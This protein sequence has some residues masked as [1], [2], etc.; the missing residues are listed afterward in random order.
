M[1]GAWRGND[2]CW[3]MAA[4]IARIIAHADGQ[5][6]L[7]KD[8]RTHLVLIDGFIGGEGNGPLDVEP[9]KSGVILFADSPTAADYA[10]ALTMGYCPESLPILQGTI[11]LRDLPLAADGFTG[12]RICVNGKNIVIDRLSDYVKVRYRPP[13]G[14]RG[15]IEV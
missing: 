2:T 7:S 3:R 11:N 1:N 4:D 15:H 10:A 8:Q 12:E 5:G 14:W 9:V 13:T 6:R